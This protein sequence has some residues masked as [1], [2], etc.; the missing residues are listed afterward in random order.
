[1]RA[2]LLA[3]SLLLLLPACDSKSE[4]PTAPEGPQV[5]GTQPPGATAPPGHPGMPPT[6]ALPPGH[7]PTPGAAPPTAQP[8]APSNPRDVTPSGQAQNVTVPG[9]TFQV[10]VEWEST[11]PS[12]SMRL[13]QWTIPGPGGDASMALFRFPGGGSADANISRWQG[14]YEGIGGTIQD[15]TKTEKI[16]VGGL[17]V[18]L[19]EIRGNFKGSAMS[20]APPIPDAIMLAAIVEGPGDPYFFKLNGPR[21]TIDV[22]DKAFRAFVQ[23]VN[24]VT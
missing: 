2:L 14:Q 7:P 4:K 6:G 22:W 9:L 23:T 11:P 10:P 20:Q 1:M 19:V 8:A 15:A 21:A 16:E 5:S 3:A 18:T 13:A 24:V 12:S 17:K